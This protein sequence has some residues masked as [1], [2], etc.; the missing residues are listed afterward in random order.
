MNIIK[1][2][3]TLW[4]VILWCGV[5]CLVSAEDAILCDWCH[6]LFCTLLVVKVYNYI[7]VI[8]LWSPSQNLS[9]DVSHVRLFENFI[10]STGLKFQI[11]DGIISLQRVLSWWYSKFVI[12]M[13]RAFQ[14]Y[15]ICRFT[16][17][18]H[19]RYVFKGLRFEMVQLH[20]RV[21][22]HG[23]FHH[24]WSPSQELSNDVSHLR[25]S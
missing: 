1:D 18:F 25:L 22:D 5:G 11:W 14:W 20:L 15:I 13:S 16:S 3:Y 21:S 12:S 19:N 7:E 17:K 24:L 9:N 8:K 6:M 4:F 2:K 10:I 23:D